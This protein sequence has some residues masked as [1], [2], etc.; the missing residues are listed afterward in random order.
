MGEHVGSI[1]LAQVV[2]VQAAM[3]NQYSK[4]P[5]IRTSIEQEPTA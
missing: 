4:S 5:H 3:I 1:N 2:I